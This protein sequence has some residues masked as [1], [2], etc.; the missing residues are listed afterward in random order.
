MPRQQLNSYADVQT[1]FDDFITANQI[2]IDDSPHGPFWNTLSYDDFVNGDVPGVAGVKILVSG[3]SANSNLVKILKGSLTVGGRTF[4]RMPG[5]G[6]FMSSDMIASLADWIDRGCPEREEDVQRRPK[7]R[8]HA[9]LQPRPD[10]KPSP[11]MDSLV[12]VIRDRIVCDTDRRG[13]STP[14]GMSPTRI[15]LDASE[16]FIPLWERDSVLRWRFRERSLDY[17]ADPE[18]AKA[19][20]RDLLSEALLAWGT[21][22]PVR[23]KYDED[24]WDFEIVMRSGDQCN[25]FG[26][27]LAAAFF[28]DS[29]RHELELYPKMLTQP[30]KEQVDTFIHEIG[31]VFGLRHF[32]ANVSETAFPSEIFGRH[33]KFSIMNYGEFSELTNLDKEDLTLL[34][35]MVWSGELTHINGTPIRL[36][37]P[38]SAFMPAPVAIT[39]C[40]HALAALQPQTAA[41]NRSAEAR[42]RLHPLA[43]SRSR[44]AYLEGK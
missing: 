18:A 13:H 32:F 42:P 26:C 39:E 2:N 7:E 29:G 41:P 44:A 34:Y 30:R 1:F 20:L 19:I 23:F 5:G 35:E 17:F 25:A 36:F 10:A 33:E 43:Q 8:R 21:A 27:V 6:P 31:H 22:A 28:P 12:H 16:G 3:S 38:Y 37:K 4:R 11:N 9:S 24:L 40:N 14:H 15:V